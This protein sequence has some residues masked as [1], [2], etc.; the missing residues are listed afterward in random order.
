MHVSN[1][2]ASAIP[3]QRFILLDFD[4]AGLTR[5]VHDQSIDFVI[6]SSGHYVALEH[7][8]GVSR[9]ATLVSPWASSPGQS[10]GSA[11][12]V[13]NDD[14]RLQALTDLAGKYVLAVDPDA[15]GGYQIAAREL[16]QAGIDPG[17]DLAKL[18]FAGFPLQNL[19]YAVRAGRVD[20]AIIRSCMLEQMMRSGEIGAGELR[21]LAPIATPA[22]QCQTSSRL[23]PDWPIAVLRHTP[24][25][26]SK[27]V[28]IALLR[29]SAT[30][31]GYS[32]AVAADYQV[33]DQMFRELNI[34][35]YAYLRQWTFEGLL[36]RY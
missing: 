14:A 1:W 3:G 24:A 9:I 17:H 6:T 8:D 4:Q 16:W 27:Q 30:A 13:R 35:P 11:I 18:E 15:F 28:A 7:S 31:D 29:M 26:L 10:I 20:A 19:A 36:R 12:V 32:W 25:Q 21:V 23:Y 22:F 2:L 5:A 34:G 33:V